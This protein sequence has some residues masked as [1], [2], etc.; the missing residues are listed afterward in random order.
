VIAARE[1]NS[2]QSIGSVGFYGALVSFGC[3]VCSFG[4]LQ[5][6]FRTWVVGQYFAGRAGWFV[7]AFLVLGFVSIL[8]AVASLFDRGPRRSAGI[9]LSAVTLA[10]VILIFWVNP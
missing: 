5:A 6:S 9:A 1:R 3:L 8:T 2:R 10:G 4:I 7:N